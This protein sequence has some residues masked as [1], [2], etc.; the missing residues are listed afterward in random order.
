MP[1]APISGMLLK[2]NI[3]VESPV[4]DNGGIKVLVTTPVV[5]ATASRMN[6]N[7]R[8][9]LMLVTTNAMSFPGLAL[10]ILVSTGAVVGMRVTAP[11][12]TILTG[13]APPE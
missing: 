5:G 9:T 7:L 12:L 8:E 3:V 11:G 2:S 10:R 4:S 6:R 1:V 13:C